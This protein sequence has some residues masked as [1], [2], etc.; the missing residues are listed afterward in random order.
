MKILMISN[1][2]PYPPTR[3]GIQVRTFNL[4]QY[5]ASHHEITLLTQRPTNATD[6]EVAYLSD[7][8]TKLVMFPQ[9]TNEKG[10]L[11]KAKRWSNFLQQGTPPH[12]LAHYSTAM[13]E[14]LDEA[15][16]QSQFELI[17]CEHSTNEIYVHSDWQQK[18]RTVVN[19]HSSISRDRRDQLDTHSSDNEL[20]DQINLPLLRLYEQRYCSKFS[21]VV[22]TTAAERKH[23]QTLA[24]EA[25]VFIIPNGVDL[26]LFPRRVANSGGQRLLFLGAMDNLADI[27][28]VRFFCLEVLPALQS[29]YP[30]T[31]I[32][33]VGSRPV[34]EIKELGELSGITI[35]GHVPSV[36]EYLHWA[37]VCVV[38]MRI[39]LGM[40]NKTLE[41]MAAGVPVVASD[42]G[43]EGLE[44]DGADVPLRA[45]RAN[46]VDE[47]V[48]AIGRLF[49][50]PKLRDKISE[51]ARSMIE[52]EY[53]WE[54]AGARYEKVLN[55]Q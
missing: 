31:T 16:T 37:T 2:F 1:A 46:S 50:E 35:T 30:E 25:E 53:M 3:G 48:Y 32:E 18:L 39:G 38:P 9:V 20:R 4:L 33:L 51:N 22:V 23:I 5:L 21:A 24:P 29:R 8:V 17:T 28:A 44:V 13:Q 43:L 6:E 14:W 10:L 49:D 27:D 52:T 54:R 7:L 47:Y 40:K 12:V 34:P 26:N 42:R 45:M 15:V 55:V 41:A 36:V 19:I 11:N